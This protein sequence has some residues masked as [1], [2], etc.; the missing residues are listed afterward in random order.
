M[1]FRSTGEPLKVQLLQTWDKLTVQN[2]DKWTE[3][4]RDEE[5]QGK[6]RGSE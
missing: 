2:K 5:P 3:E 6:G 1:I 4:N